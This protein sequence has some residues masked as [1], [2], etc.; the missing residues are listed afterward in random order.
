L[1]IFKP[2]LKDIEN[3]QKLLKPFVDDGIILLRDKNEIATNIR[4]YSAVEIDKK[5]VGIVALHIYSDELAEVR[6]LAVD[7]AYQ[8]KGIGKKLI[9]SIEE[10]AKIL[11]VKQILTL[12]YQKEFFQNIGFIE[13]D[14]ESIPE[15]KVWADCIKCKHFPMCNEISM[16]K[17]I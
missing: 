3:I 17:N 6:S 9:K 5:I 1:I 7:K 14:K 8:Q 16:I 15:Q 11:G 12:T 10:E 13:I 4:S 2:K